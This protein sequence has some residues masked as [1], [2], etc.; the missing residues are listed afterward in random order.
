MKNYKNS[1]GCDYATC[2]IGC[3]FAENTIIKILENNKEINMKMGIKNTLKL[4]FLKNM[5]M[6]LNFMKLK[7]N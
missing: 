7:Q 1:K 3:C 4:T 6:I 2:L 5:K